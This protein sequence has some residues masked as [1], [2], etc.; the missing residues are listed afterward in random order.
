[1]TLTTNRKQ[2][3]RTLEGNIRKNA[4]SIQKNGLEIGRD[5]IEIRDDELWADD[6][7]SWNQYLKDM[8]DELVGKSFSQAKTLI[9]AAVVSEKV[10]ERFLTSKTGTTISASGIAELR[11]LAP[12]TDSAKNNEADYSKIRNKDVARVLKKAVEIAGNE[13]PSVRDIRKAVDHDLGVD[14]SAKTKETK[15]RND[16]RMRKRRGRFTTP[17]PPNLLSLAPTTTN[18]S[19]QVAG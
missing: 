19:R 9:D 2:R 11:R 10:P 4:E 12:R 3:L 1:M 8:A 15:E 6:Y 7:Q 17:P 13:S 18:N 14:R 16:M 5:L